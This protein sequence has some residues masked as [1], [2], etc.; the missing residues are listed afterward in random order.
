MGCSVSVN[1]DKD[2]DDPN[3]APDLDNDILVLTHHDGFRQQRKMSKQYNLGESLKKEEVLSEEEIEAFETGRFVRT[4]KDSSHYCIWL[5]PLP[6]R[7][8]PRARSFSPL[9]GLIN[10]QGAW[11]WKGYVLKT[12]TFRCGIRQRKQ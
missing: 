9:D 6:G 7:K 5:S 3:P 12:G 10:S 1:C 2:L 8:F 4:K 11:R